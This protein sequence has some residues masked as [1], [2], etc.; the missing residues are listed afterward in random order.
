MKRVSNL[1]EQLFDLNYIFLNYEI[2]KKNTKNKQKINKFE[3]NLSINILRIIYLIKNYQVNKYNM[4]IVYEPKKRLILSLNL[5]DKVINHMVANILY[6]VLDKS[7]IDSNVAVRKNKGTAYALKLV[8]KYLAE[9]HN[10][11]VLK[12]DIAKYFYNIDHDILKRSLRNKI[13]DEKFL[14]LLDKIIDSTNQEYIIKKAQEMGFDYVNYHKGISIGCFTSQIFAIY[15]L[16]DLDHY[17]KE[18]LKIKH[19][20]RYM[21]DFIL[22]HSD[23]E[24]LKECLIKIKIFLIK[25]K[26]NLNNKTMI[27][28]NNFTFLGFRFNNQECKIISKNKRRIYKKLR[29]LKTK[30]YSQYLKVLASY[31]GFFK[32]QKY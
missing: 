12:C 2:V 11:Y 20:I 4:F 29:K 30:D 15:Y 16:N 10:Y 5:Y 19:Y 27:S 22:I 6:D 32:N 9:Y 24:Y 25:Y 28:K 13:K 7:L 17:I 14:N 31:Q 21:D 3:E 23:K 1:Y 8:K 18:K 26:L